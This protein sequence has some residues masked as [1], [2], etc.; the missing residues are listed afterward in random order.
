M[1]RLILLVP[2]VACGCLG[3]RADPSTFFVITATVGLET[4][5]APLAATLGLGPL[6]LPGYLDRSEL[7]TRLSENQLAVSEIERWAEPFPD[8]V[9]RAVSDNLVR[10][11]RPDDYVTYPWYESSQVD[12]GIAVDVGRFEADSTG[13]VTLAADWRITSGNPGVTLYRGASLIQENASGATTDESVAA[14]SRALARLCDEIAVAVRRLHAASRQ[15]A[16]GVRR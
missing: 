6:T 11:L 7:V 2:L 8:N 13:A 5:A 9:L 12:Y 15:S 3:P 4:S 14:Q 1:R 16:P 10:L